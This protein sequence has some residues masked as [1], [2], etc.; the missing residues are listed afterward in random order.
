MELFL[1]YQIE[2]S[3]YIELKLVNLINFVPVS[4][5]YSGCFIYK[6]LYFQPF[7]KSFWL[8]AIGGISNP[9]AAKMTFFFVIYVYGFH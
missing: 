3:V 5:P 1:C 8:S 9:M 2:R 7:N 4:S 6:F